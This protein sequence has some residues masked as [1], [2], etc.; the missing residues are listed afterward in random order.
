MSPA[1]SILLPRAS[2]RLR[3]PKA[4]FIEAGLAQP[5]IAEVEGEPVA[6][7][8]IFR[9]AS[10]AWYMYGASRATHREKMPNHLLQW[11]AMRWA[12]EQGCPWSCNTCCYAAWRGHLE[13]LQWARKQGC[14]WDWRT[15][16]YAAE[17]GHMEVLQ[18]A[19]KQGCPWDK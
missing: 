3:N 17:R 10:K 5:L 7:V 15:C 11:E 4:A 19:R 9:F 8:L 6:L 16:A 12:R 13:V 1:T 14:S 18:W 2:I